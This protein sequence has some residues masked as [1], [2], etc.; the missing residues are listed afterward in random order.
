MPDLKWLQPGVSRV[1]LEAKSGRGFLQHYS[2]LF[3]LDLCLQTFF[4]SL[5][6]KRRLTLANEANDKLALKVAEQ[7]EGPL[8]QYDK[9]RKFHIYSGDGH[10]H[11]ASPHEER[12]DG[13][14]WAAGLFYLLN[15]RSHA[16]T[17]MKNADQVERKH[18]HNMLALKR[19]GW[20]ELRKHA[21]ARTGEKVLIARDSACTDF[22]F[23][24]R[25]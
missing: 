10:W 1:L 4:A 6:S 5:R 20:K 12:K 21:D 15:L 13:K 23:L 2:P 25:M 17:H 14:K 9:L 8:S 22:A 24:G 19:T 18:E 16:L 3:K 11:G 7:I